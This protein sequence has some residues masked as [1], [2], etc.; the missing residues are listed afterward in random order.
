MVPPPL[1]PLN[2]RPQT[3]RPTSIA[4]FIRMPRQHAVK[5]WPAAA[6]AWHPAP[7]HQVL[8][9]PTQPALFTR[10]SH[11]KVGLGTTISRGG[12]ARGPTPLLQTEAARQ[13]GCQAPARHVCN[14]QN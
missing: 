5:P 1:P 2:C 11:E 9:A 10:G 14:Q 7:P 6:A 12:K 8:G 13:R 4:I 3:C